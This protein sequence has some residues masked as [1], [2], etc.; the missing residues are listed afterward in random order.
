[1]T[2]LLT[3]RGVLIL[4]YTVVIDPLH[5]FSYLSYTAPAAAPKNFTFELSEQQLTLSWAALEQEE[6]R[7]RLLA[8]KVQWSQG[9]ESQ[10]HHCK[11]RTLIKEILQ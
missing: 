3:C 8:Y 4:V 1:M 11:R 9:G 7:G 2:N 6:L 10:V 5:L